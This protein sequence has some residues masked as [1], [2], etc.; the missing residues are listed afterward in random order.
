MNYI[1][2][3]DEI[4]LQDIGLVGG[5]NASLGQMIVDLTQKG[6]AVPHGFAIT[7]RAYWHF[8]S[9]NSLLETLKQIRGAINVSDPE[10]L[11][12]GAQHIRTTIINGHYPLDLRN[13]IISAYQHL[14]HR[15]HEADCDVAVRSS[16]TAED[17]PGASFAGQQ[18]TYLHIHSV[19]SL[20]ESVKKCFASLFTE[21]AIVYRKEKGFDDFAIGLSVG[22]QKMIR[23]DLAVSG[24]A[25]SLDTETGFKDA[26]IIDASYGLGE[27]IVQGKVTPDEFVVHKPTLALGYKPIIKKKLGNKN[28]RFR[29]GTTV[30]VIEESVSDTDQHR[31]C[32]ADD[33][34]IEL[35]QSVATIE[36]HYSALAGSW[37]PMD[38]EWAKDG[39]DGKL[40]IIQARPETVHA[41]EPAQ[42]VYSHYVL[43]TP[44]QPK[45]LVTGQS[46]GQQIVT[47]A[48]RI[49][50]TLAD[51]GAVQKGDIIV[52]EMTDPD[53]LP[54]L[55]K[56]RG[57]ITDKGGRTCHAAIVARELGIAALVGTSDA[58]QLLH[59]GQE[60]TLDC[61]Q[62]MQ[63]A[64]Y[65]GL[66]PF[67]KIDTVL[68]PLP[69]LTS[70]IMINL[71]DP[72]RAFSCASL[73]VD[74]VGLARLEF[75]INS[76]IKVHPMALLYQ[77]KVLDGEI[78]NSIDVITNGYES[79][80]DFFVDVLAQGIGMIAAAFYPKPVIVR[81]SDFKSNEYGNLIGGSYFEPE[82]ENPMIGFRGASR[83]YHHAYEPAF[84][85]ECAAIKK[86]R[87]E[88]GL[89]NVKIM[90][91]FVRTIKEAQRV[92][93]LLDEQGLKSGVDGLEII[94]MCEVPSNVILIDQF[95][96]YFDGFSIGS[97]DLTQ[98]TL[99]IDRDSQLLLP[100]FDERDP[101]VMRMI[102]LAI[103]GAHE[104][105]KHI[106][107]CGQAPSDYPEIA[108][109]LLARAIDSISLNPDTVI[110]FLQHITEKRAILQ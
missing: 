104:K 79:G 19:D 4:G 81:F 60:V 68:E 6:I 73:P 3:F 35:A 61:S 15:Y 51:V 49:V 99:G 106:G 56:A 20:L 72:D 78:R 82:E 7:A 16:A 21:R 77:E 103:T 38:I 89:T 34:I 26:I 59:N 28:I 98:L 62:G 5:K 70:K 108:H 63:G 95:S 39:K 1:K 67:K 24:V 55:K 88:M 107:I 100:L 92:I 43:D 75:V 58:T 12:S 53:W 66:I 29:Y 50:K 47:G 17:L 13:E 36:N 18:E 11:R 71:A 9:F 52:T 27:A 97:N 40:Y 76:E 10:S 33:E 87:S 74:G 48:A 45:A 25:F 14:S 54:V 69:T 22:V 86:V 44:T 2:R 64:V 96:N 57:I 65:D 93:E 31:F 85:L 102:E 101:A 90:I 110:P 83:Y 41:K 91:P 32:L 42:K 30:N 105:H 46:I 109:W 37:V 84:L 23:S 80:A 8:I 94:M